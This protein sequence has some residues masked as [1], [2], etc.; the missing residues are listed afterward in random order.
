MRA[1]SGFNATASVS[2]LRQLLNYHEAESHCNDELFCTAK[3]NVMQIS[4]SEN[5]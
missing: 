5:K 1:Q 4:V 2:S 3:N